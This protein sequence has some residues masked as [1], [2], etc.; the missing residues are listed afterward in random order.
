MRESAFCRNSTLTTLGTISWRRTRN[1]LLKSSSLKAGTLNSK[2]Q[3]LKTDA[4]MNVFQPTYP[5]GGK[6]YRA[7][8]RLALKIWVSVDVLLTLPAELMSE[9]SSTFRYSCLQENG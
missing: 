1:R 6:E 2:Q 3:W 5:P 9:N 8:T 7:V 4:A